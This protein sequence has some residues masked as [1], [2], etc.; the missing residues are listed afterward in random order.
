M[1]SNSEPKIK[2]KI[3]PQERIKYPCT[4][5]IALHCPTETP[6]DFLEILERRC[7]R[8]QLGYVS[9]EELGS[10][11]FLSTRTKSLER[12]GL[13]LTVE[14]RNYPS[15][16]ALHTIDCFVT[17][18]NESYW[19]VYN[20]IKHTLDQISSAKSTELDDFKARCQSMLP[21]VATGYL[22]WYLCDIDRLSSKYENPASLAFRESGS[23]SAVQSL[24][25][26]YLGLSYC[27]L[28]LHGNEYVKYL[29]HKR[30]LMGVGTAVIG[31]SVI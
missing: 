17:G 8:R 25:A 4:N 12:G 27:M 19:Y 23:I 24:V 5:S 1:D 10:L 30:Q 21:D 3:M 15:A 18:F 13:G 28:G 31:G 26:E 16:G 14:K 9:L 7:S 22:I 11:F 29:S 6:A 2:K 20:P